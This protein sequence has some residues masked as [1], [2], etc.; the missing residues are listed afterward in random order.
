[1]E[2]VSQKGTHYATVIHFQG[3]V[4]ELKRQ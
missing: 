4:Q 3:R 1:M 2:R